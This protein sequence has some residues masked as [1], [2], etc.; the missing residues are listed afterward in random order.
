MRS[1]L[2]LMLARGQG[3]PGWAAAGGARRS[4]LSRRHPAV[5]ARR[6]RRPTRFVRCA[7][8]AQTGGGKS[9]DEARCA[10]GP[11]EL[12]SSAPRQRPPQPTRAH[13]GRSR[14][15]CSHRVLGRCSAAGAVWAGAI[16]G[17]EQRRAGVGA[18]SAHPPLTRRHCSSTA[19]A[20]SGASL[21]TRP[22]TEQRS[23]VGPPGRPPPLA[24]AQ[25]A[26]AAPLDAKHKHTWSH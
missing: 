22:R 2:D 6:A 15:D 5:L 20:V 19:N 8:C 11:C 21:A 13:L 16:G 24:P 25:A 9:V 23:G 4:A 26:P 3:V 18:R 1:G 14:R 10:R 17:G 12:R 7:H